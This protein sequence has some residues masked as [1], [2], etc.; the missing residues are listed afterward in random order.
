MYMEKQENAYTIISGNVSK[1]VF[2]VTSEEV[3]EAQ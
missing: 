3:L 2:I 1:E